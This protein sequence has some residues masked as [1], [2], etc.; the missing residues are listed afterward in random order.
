MCL[1]EGNFIHLR[2]RIKTGRADDCTWMRVHSC[3]RH[4][5][6]HGTEQGI[7]ASA[8]KAQHYQSKVT[9]TESILKFV[10]AGGFLEY[11]LMS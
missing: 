4:I 6:A 3:V 11:V 9:T 8:I 1:S 5:P 10:C 7:V 2:G